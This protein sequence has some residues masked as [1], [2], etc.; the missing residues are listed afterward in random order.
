MCSDARQLEAA[1]RHCRAVVAQRAKNFAYAFLLLPPARRRGR[2]AIYAYCR[3]ADDFADDEGLAQDERARRLADLRARLRAAL[4]ESAADGAGAPPHALAPDR[5]LDLLMLALRDTA[6][7]F[8]VAR[9]DLDLVAQ[10]CEQDLT[11][12][13]YASWEELRGY[14]YM[15]A[16]AV[17]LACLEVFG[18][19]GEREELRARAVDLGLAMQLTNIIRD[20]AEDLARD[21]IYLP[22]E[23]LARFG[24]DEAQLAA[25]RVDE[26]WRALLAFEV[27]RARELFASGRQLAPA[28][29]RRSRVCPLALA[30]IYERLL[31]EVERAD[32]DVFSRRVALSGGQKLRLLGRCLAPAYLGR[33]AGAA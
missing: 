6:L 14:C 9:H 17:G 10:G 3:I 33:G 8:G 20:V 1:Y 16:S 22:Q 30:A 18:Y 24:V 15:V 2:E 19:R 23:D 11:V 5:E 7:R 32:Y 13:R 21:R 27:A 12:R 28:V 25:G 29:R 4:P 31:D 26:R